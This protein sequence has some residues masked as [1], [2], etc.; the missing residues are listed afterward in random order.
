[1]LSSMKKDV[2]L[3]SLK[4]FKNDYQQVVTQDGRLNQR[5]TFN[6]QF[7]MVKLGLK[8]NI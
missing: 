7:V 5:T 2:K 4:K 8:D 1:M 6:K 3:M